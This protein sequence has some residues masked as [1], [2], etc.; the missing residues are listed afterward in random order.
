MVSNGAYVLTEDSPH[1]SIRLTKNPRFYD[2]AHV[3]IDDVIFYPI[4]DENIT[5]TRFR[6]REIDINVTTS[7]FPIEQLPWLQQNMP[8]EARIVPALYNE[9]LAFNLTRPPFKDIRLRQA[10][11][12]CIDRQIITSKVL[13]DG[14]TPAYAFVPP[15]VANYPNTARVDFASW[16]M[17]QRI[18]EAKRL[19]GGGRVQCRSSVHPGTS[20][21]EQH[22]VPPHGH[23]AAAMLKDCGIIDRLI[24]NEPKV[25]YRTVQEGDFTMATAG[26]AADYN[27]AQTFLYLLDSRSAGFNYGGYSNPKFDALLD[28]AKAEL[29]VSKR[30]A[31]LGH[32]EQIALDDVAV[33]PL[34]FPSSRDL[35]AP[36]VKGYV[37][38]AT[39]SHPTRWMRLER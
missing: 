38:N 16:P 23:R 14:S 24:A 13:K 33:A 2:A 5:L 26:W 15:G 6:S 21:Q 10:V 29:D 20:L 22:H 9:Y 4:E 31:P 30:A 27:D 35:V 28:Q 32:A 11:S 7:S 12:L 25:F 18:A 17:A 8:G 39:N 1:N 19:A 37:D 36:Y 34:N 3:A